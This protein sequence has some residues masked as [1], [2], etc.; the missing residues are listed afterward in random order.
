M[1]A[2]C[3]T[4]TGDVLDRSMEVASFTVKRHLG[5]VKFVEP[6]LTSPV[7]NFYP[8]EVKL[9]LWTTIRLGFFLCFF[10]QHVFFN[11][12]SWG[13][14]WEMDLFFWKSQ[15]V[16]KGGKSWGFCQSLDL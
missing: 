7:G 13:S 2:H 6:S 3:S 11:R 9:T 1:K 16:S 4:V 10:F 5:E 14:M 15:T 12:Q 8:M